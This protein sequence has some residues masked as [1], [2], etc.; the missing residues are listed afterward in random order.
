M[1][2]GN[3]HT[4][5]HTSFF[6]LNF[7]TTKIMSMFTA[8]VLPVFRSEN[9]LI[10]LLNAPVDRLNLKTRAQYLLFIAISFRPP[11]VV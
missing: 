5:L 10:W 3:I 1:S 8:G 4:S 11:C 9:S 2:K 7:Y 6:K